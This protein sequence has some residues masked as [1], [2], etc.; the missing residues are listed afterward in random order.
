MDD[1]DPI[2]LLSDSEI[3]AVAAGH[4]G[5]RG[6]NNSVTIVEIVD[7]E[8]GELVANASGNANVNVEIAGIGNNSNSSSGGSSS[9][10]GRGRK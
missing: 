6:N 5:I 3:E 2:R 8:I 1:L 7:V 10:H 9:R 4:G